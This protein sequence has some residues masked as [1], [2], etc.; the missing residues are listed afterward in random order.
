MQIKRSD[1]KVTKEDLKKS[2][3]VVVLIKKMAIIK[4]HKELCVCFYTTIF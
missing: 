2:S 4:V 1:L 3:K